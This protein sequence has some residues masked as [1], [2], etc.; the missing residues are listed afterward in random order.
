MGSR[1]SVNATD[2]WHTFYPFQAWEDDEGEGGVTYECVEDAE[3]KAYDIV[4]GVDVLTVDGLAD[5]L[6]ARI[7][8][9]T[10]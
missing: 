9:F 3:E 10:A 2:T 5:W 7:Q 4:R 8:S 1:P 6:K